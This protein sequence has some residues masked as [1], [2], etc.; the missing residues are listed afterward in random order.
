MR[1]LNNLRAA[2]KRVRFV[3]LAIALFGFAALNGG[4]A[5]A[6]S[7]NIS[8]GSATKCQYNLVNFST[9]WSG[10]APYDVDFYADNSAGTQFHYYH[11]YSTSRSILA[12]YTDPGWF[13]PDIWVGDFGCSGSCG[14]AV[15]DS[16]ILVNAS[17]TGG[18]P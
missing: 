5:F 3:P 6:T 2:S 11:T 13:Y 8:P 1:I 15:D 16:T 7:A 9:S 14:F 12:Q 4:T 17:G 10:N 18:C